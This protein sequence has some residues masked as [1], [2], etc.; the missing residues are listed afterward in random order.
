M[1]N[2]SMLA[3]TVIALVIA[4]LW[5]NFILSCLVWTLGYTFG[6]FLS[7]LGFAHP[8]LSLNIV[9]LGYGVLKYENIDLLV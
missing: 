1:K 7:E 3:T 9:R 4:L 5:Y 8:F 6:L 2:K